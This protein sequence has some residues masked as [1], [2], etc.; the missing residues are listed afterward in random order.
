ML[1]LLLTAALQGGGPVF[2]PGYDLHAYLAL[3]TRYA[4]GQRAAAL[5]DLRDWRS[6]EVEKALGALRHREQDLRAAPSEGTDVDF[7]TVEA[8][9]LLH[10]EAGLLELSS[11]AMVD[12]EWQFHTST[13]LYRWSH[14]AAAK[15][16]ERASRGA[17]RAES[18]VLP[19]AEALRVQE[20]IGARDYYLALG[21]TSLAMGFPDVARPFAEEV[22]QAAP[23]DAEAHLLLGCVA[24][25]LATVF[26]LRHQERNAER[27]RVEAEKALRD[28]LAVDAGLPEARLRLGKLLLDQR[29][30]KEAA[31]WLLGL[32]EGRADDRQRYL[33]RLFLG[34]LLDGRGRP[35]EAARWY[36]RALESWPDSQA[37]RF[38]LAQLLEEPAGVSAANEQVSA[39]LDA[40]RRPDRVADPWWTY[41]YGPP[42]VSRAALDRLLA[43]VFER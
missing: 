32:D 18:G 25:S 16:R 22:V 35:E 30:A 2:R 43:R 10:A 37:A 6:V 1:V 42:G 3:A 11:A 34:R 24:E 4:S 21:S 19:P 33:A 5:R 29:R 12:A 27:A 9:V 28:S 14:A 7:R 36:E 38:G 17:G 26:A 39:T 40:A 23:L 8:A 31:P 41:T 15:L 13:E 20:R